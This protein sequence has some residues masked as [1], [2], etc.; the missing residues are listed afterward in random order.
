M[1]QACSGRP[2][3]DKVAGREIALE[4]NIVHGDDAGGAA[5]VMQPGR[6]ERRLPV[7]GVDDI[8]PPGE[9]RGGLP[10]QRGDPR[11]QAE[12]DAVIGPVVAERVEI[13]V[14]RAREK[15]WAVEQDQ[16]QAVGLGGEQTGR[17]QRRRE[18]R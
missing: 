3:A 11:K 10:E 18:R 2:S 1:C 17:R 13:G 5:F 9:R 6:G 7:V 4:G 14:A 16:R 8:G 15:R 12:A